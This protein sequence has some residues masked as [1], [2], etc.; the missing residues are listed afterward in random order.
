MNSSDY[1]A[2]S[3]KEFSKAAENYETDSAGIY[4]MCRKDYPDILEEL[5]KEEFNDLLDCGC[6]TG[7]MISLLH[8]KYPE[9]NYTGIDLT[10]KMIETAK[11]KGIEGANFVLG[12]CE[13]LPFEENSFDAVICSMS[14]HHYPEPQKFFS[15]VYRILRPEGRLILRDM[16]MNKT[17]R[18]LAN[19][20]EMPLVNA[21]GKGDVKVY[22]REDIEKLCRDSG[23]RLE[24]FE[25]RRG[26][27]L[28]AVI[29][30]PSQK[31]KRIDLGD[32]QETALIPLA[33]KSSES[34]SKEPRFYDAKAVEI[35]RE[36]D[37]DTKK[38][39]KYFS[40]EGVVA[41]SILFDNEAKAIIRRHPDAV[42]VNI[43]SGFD[44]RFSR[45]DNGSIKWY[46][47]DLPDSIALRERVFDKQERVYNIA[48]DLTEKDW[49][50]NIPADGTT[51]LIAEGLLMYFTEAQV[52]ELLCSIREHFHKGYLLAELMHP[53]AVKNEKHHDTLKS[54]NAHFRWGIKD[55]RE[56]EKLCEGWKLLKEVSFFEEMKK[57]SLI[58]KIGNKLMA[59]KMDRLAVY[60]FK[61]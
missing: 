8:E 20:L 59:D 35:V 52:A 28:H 12:D 19:K 11:A 7:P 22:G 25:Q 27:R 14:F 40:H 48:A 3:I 15:S 47:V 24:S 54:T 26:L 44:D 46:N 58:G 56:A 38:Y 9:K 23:L 6:G 10:P 21:V 57:Y 55:G 34:L 18:W 30:K 53:M 13:D 4:K 5:E 16:T 50:K 32:V 29:R 45:V 31:A 51:V 36:L 17:A 33:I 39:D 42:F 60:R 37:F 61:K 43:G 49:A 2:L 1:K 41:R